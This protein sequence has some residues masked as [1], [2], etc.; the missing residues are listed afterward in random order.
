MQRIRLFLWLIFTAGT[1]LLSQADS[2]AGGGGGMSGVI[3]FSDSNTNGQSDEQPPEADE[4]SGAAASI[5]SPTSGAS[6]PPPASATNVR[7][8]PVIPQ[9]TGPSVSLR[10]PTPLLPKAPAV[11]R[12]ANP[13]KLP[14]T[15]AATAPKPAPRVVQ[16]KVQ[17]LRRTFMLWLNQKRSN[18]R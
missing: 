7:I 9:N 18:N 4:A 6:A 17:A 12:T 3:G 11:K 13:T 1:L 16:K 10:K 8:V 15:K 2:A 14:S 5:L